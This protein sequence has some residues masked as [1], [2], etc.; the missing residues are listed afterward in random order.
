MANAKEFLN[1][2]VLKWTYDVAVY[3]C[4]DNT[5]YTIGYVPAGA[6]V[7]GGYGIVRTAFDDG[8]DES[9]TVSIGYAATAAGLM[10]ATAGSALNAIT[11]KA[12]TLL[13]GC[14]TLGS[15]AADGDTAAEFAG[16]V[17][18]AYIVTTART[19][20]TVTLSNDTDFTA[21][22]IDVYIEYVV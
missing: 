3:G 16:L 21:G 22:K 8:D 14:P 2:R 11:N 5:T 17:A 15:N 10:A 19:A 1:K 13:P 4:V 6:I 18:D 12:F 9:T 20:I 7:T